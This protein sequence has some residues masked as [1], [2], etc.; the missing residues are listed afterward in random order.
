VP[1]WSDDFDDV[2]KLADYI[3][4]LNGIDRVEVLP[5]HKMGEHKWQDLGMDYELTETPPPSLELVERVR[6]QFRERG[7]FTC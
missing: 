1:G 3:K 4:T 2:E 7:L 5:F 6:N